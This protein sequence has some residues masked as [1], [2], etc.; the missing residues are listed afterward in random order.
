MKAKK[1]YGLMAL[2]AGSFA[3]APAAAAQDVT[4][5][6]VSVS[7]FSCDNNTKYFSNWRD[8]WFIQLGAGV[9]QPFV[10]RGW[11]VKDPGHTVDR[12]KMTTVYNFGFGRW[13]SPYL[14]VRVNALGGALHW[15]NPTV[16]E[17]NNGWARAKHANLNVDLMWDMFNSFA[18]PNPNRVFSIIP[19]VGIGGDCMWDIR[20]SKGNVAAGTNIYT[21]EGRLRKMSW[22]LPVSAGIQFRLRLCKYVDFF[23]EARSNF[24]GDNWNGCA[25]G[26][27]I[28]A[29]VTAYGGLSFNING[30]GWETY[31]ECNNLSTI[32][33]LNNE[34]NNLRGEVLASA[35]AIS[36]LESQLP[37]PQ[38][39]TVTKV[40][41]TDCA[42][43]PLMTTVRFAIDSDVISPEEEVN[44]YN[45]GEWLKANPDQQI[46]IVGY[47]DKDTGTA[48]Y[49]LELS[50][51]RANAVAE[52]LI[53]NYGIAKSRL[54]IKADG[55]NVQPYKTN[56]WNRIVIF[57][58]E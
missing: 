18:G 17:P 37:C 44:V 25:N 23:A 35:A 51:R 6:S 13:F 20:D 53:N 15:N 28:E 16:A 11:G 47:A 31:N 3:L 21:D 36:A 9:N 58:Q 52:Q 41:K 22:T 42:N 38:A 56:D 57:T 12:Q 34:V 49:N 40:V 50:Q 24:Y 5:E 55:S 45:M 1:F 26:K 19:Y 27:P 2:C 7:E 8:N 29:N 46:T 30:R 14:A 48:E 39:N 43:A 33:S 32:A 54:T 10:E 4:V